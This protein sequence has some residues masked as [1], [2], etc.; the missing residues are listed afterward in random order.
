M[1]NLKKKKFN[2]EKLCVLIFG[3]LFGFMFDLGC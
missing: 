3:I 2:L 1:Y